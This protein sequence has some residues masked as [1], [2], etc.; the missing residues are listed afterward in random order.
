M[1]YIVSVLANTLLFYVLTRFNISRFDV[2]GYANPIVVL[3]AA[4]LIMWT[5]QLN[6]KPS[7][8]INFVGAS[9]FAVFLLHGNPNIGVPVYKSLM[10]YLYTAFSGFTC[11]VVMFVALVLIFTI[12]V[13][14]DQPRKWI[15]SHVSQYV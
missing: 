10:Q 6:I 11:L 2:I 3:G 4:E 12:A 8:V 13:L 15:W 14:L 5:A 7:K 9:S 1:I